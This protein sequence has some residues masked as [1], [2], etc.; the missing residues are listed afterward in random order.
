MVD[1]YSS[2]FVNTFTMKKVIIIAAAIVI[3]GAMLPVS[4]S[5]FKSYDR[6]VEVKGLCE[7]EVKADKVIWPLTFKI[8]NNDLTAALA[9]IDKANAAIV[10][11]LKDGGID[12]SEI[13]IATPRINDKYTSSEYGNNDRQ[14]R[15]LCTSVVTVCTGNVD[16]V[17]A[18]LPRQSELMKDGITLFENEWDDNKI[19]FN[20]E[21]LNEIKP[22]MI[23]EATKNA[24]EAAIKFAQDSES[25][26]GKIKTATQ[27]NF[28]I[29]ARDANTPQIKRVRVVTS[30]T[31]YL[32]R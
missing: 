15:Y 14:F 9:N 13:N 26:L 4:V 1:S 22:M 23:E 3:A 5:K 25:S 24:R 21:G 8:A 31:Y 18:L 19:R 28:S 20:F 10:K 6:T 7:R 29:E 11:F 27:G 2:Y 17:L 12:E 16:A 32:N 30:V